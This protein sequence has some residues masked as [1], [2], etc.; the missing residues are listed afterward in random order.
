MRELFKSVENQMN[1]EKT[2]EELRNDLAMLEKRSVDKLREIQ[3]KQREHAD[4]LRDI[5]RCKKA[6]SEGEESSE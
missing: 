4:I 1:E 6:M 2:I 3:E 5:A